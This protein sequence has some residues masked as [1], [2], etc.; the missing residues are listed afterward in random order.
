[1]EEHGA[2]LD[3][4]TGVIADPA[5]VF[6]ASVRSPARFPGPIPNWRG[7]S[8]APGYALPDVGFRPCPARAA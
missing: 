7:S 6:A 2:M 1:M 4:I 8:T 3:E 5:E